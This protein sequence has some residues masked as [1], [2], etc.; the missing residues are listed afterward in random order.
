MKKTI[1]LLFLLVS[2]PAF[3]QIALATNMG[4]LRVGGGVG[5]GFGNND[6]FALSVNPNIGYMLTPQLEGGL[7][8]GY[9]YSKWANVKSNLF[10]VGP[11]LTLYPVEGLFLRSRYEYFTGNFKI[12]GSPESVNR[13]ENALW[14]GG[15]Y[16]SSGKVAFYA[17]AEYN[18]LW[19][20]EKSMFSNGFR[21]IVGVSV[22]F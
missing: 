15:G 21:P 20:K 1:F 3:S 10:G 19:K 4:K 7:T 2:I 13:D 9:Q 16:G 6:Y 14:L 18:V 8:L 11:Y 5:L 12:K 17:G 22:G